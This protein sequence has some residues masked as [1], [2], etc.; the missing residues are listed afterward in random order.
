GQ[1]LFLQLKRREG[2]DPEMVVASFSGIVASD[3]RLAA[4]FV[5]GIRR[6]PAI[7]PPP[8]LMRDDHCPSSEGKRTNVWRKVT[9]PRT[10]PMRQTSGTRKN[11]ETS[12]TGVRLLKKELKTWLPLL[13]ANPH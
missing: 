2:S 7:R 5:G 4:N 3:H 6:S 13:R 8:T 1:G 12:H 10:G 11:C 9:N